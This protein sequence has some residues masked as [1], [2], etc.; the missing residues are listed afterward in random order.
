MH[1]TDTVHPDTTLDIHD[2][3]ATVSDCNKPSAHSR[4]SGMFG[5][6]AERASPTE[7]GWQLRHLLC[8]WLEEGVQGR[9]EVRDLVR[10]RGSRNVQECALALLLFLSLVGQTSVHQLCR[11]ALSF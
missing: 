10:L 1:W 8:M 11:K 2:T 6:F 7:G 3:Q 4:L 5:H 9:L